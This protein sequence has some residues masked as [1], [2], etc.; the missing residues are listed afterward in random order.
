MKN[1]I[2]EYW[3]KIESGEI[4]AC[5][6]L[7]QQYQKLVDE[8]KNPRDPWIFDIEKASRPI[9]FIEK[10]CKHSKGKWIGRASCRERV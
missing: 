5:K 6:R 9:Q 10:F 4:Q 2:L 8:I 3:A 7:R 1:Y